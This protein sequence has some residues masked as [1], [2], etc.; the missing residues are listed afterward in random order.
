MVRSP[1][2]PVEVF[3]ARSDLRLYNH[4]HRPARNVVEREREE[5]ICVVWS[6][7]ESIQLKILICEMS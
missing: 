2:C 1:K 4:K 3:F 6:E 7:A 5:R